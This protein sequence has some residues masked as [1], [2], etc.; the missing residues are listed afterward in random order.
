MKTK[1]TDNETELRSLMT[2]VMSAPLHPLKEK[3]ESMEARIIKLESTTGESRVATRQVN[4]AVKVNHTELR[5]QLDGLLEELQE[6]LADRVEP[7]VRQL[8]TLDYQQQSLLAT[9]TT[10]QVKASQREKELQDAVAACGDGVQAS[11][12]QLNGLRTSTATADVRHAAALDASLERLRQL[13]DAV[14]AAT[15]HYKG[16]LM[17][18]QG[19]QELTTAALAQQHGLAEGI[20]SAQQ[21]QLAA[22]QDAAQVLPALLASLREDLGAALSSRVEEARTSILLGTENQGAQRQHDVLA[23]LKLLRTLT[24]VNLLALA[25]IAGLAVVQF[26]GRG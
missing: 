5:N 4:E 25:G 7:L 24:A 15:A 20:A 14:D 11:L 10:A 17:T 19:G 6:G 9:L 26:V 12:T 3:M 8:A 18:L 1:S 23:N 16:A 21:A 22:Q 13:R 2:R